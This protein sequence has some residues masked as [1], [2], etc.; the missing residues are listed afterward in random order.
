MGKGD[1]KTKRGKIIMGSFG[2]RRRRK[3]INKPEIKPVKII[4]ETEVKGKK[5]PKEKKEA[6]IV[7]EP[8]EIKETTVVRAEKEVKE[9]KKVKERKET[10]SAKEEKGIKESKAEKNVKEPKAAKEAKP[11]KAAKAKQEKKVTKPKKEK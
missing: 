7:P 10:K 6:R 1:K 2:V 4:K 3:K 11:K 8:V 5:L 9:I